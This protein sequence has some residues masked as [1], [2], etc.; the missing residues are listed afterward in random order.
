MGGVVPASLPV[1]GQF[2]TQGFLQPLKLNNQSATSSWTDCQAQ[3]GN[4]SHR[5]THR[6]RCSATQVNMYH[7]SRSVDSRL[8]PSS[9][10]P[11][12]LLLRVEYV[13]VLFVQFPVVDK[14]AYRERRTFANSLLT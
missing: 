10:T 12:S 7:N 8:L 13:A 9:F 5:H 4:P 2:W 11:S 6:P 14:P 1:S 3:N